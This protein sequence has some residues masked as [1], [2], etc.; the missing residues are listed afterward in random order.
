MASPMHTFTAGDRVRAPNRE[1]FPDGTV[2]KVMTVDYLLVSWGDAELLETAHHAALV[3]VG[4]EM[5][6]NF[7]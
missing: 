3:K 4:E 2:L 1:Q 6:A 5:P 7:A